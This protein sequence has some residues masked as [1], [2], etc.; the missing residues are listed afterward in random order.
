M[1]QQKLNE[2]NVFAATEPF[3]DWRT[4]QALRFVWKLLPLATRGLSA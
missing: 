4:G 1:T 2:P 3:S